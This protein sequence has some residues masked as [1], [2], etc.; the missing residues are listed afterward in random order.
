[1]A[2]RI[3]VHLGRRG[4]GGL[5]IALPCST[6]CQK[7]RAVPVATAKAKGCL[8]SELQGNRPIGR[9]TAVLKAGVFNRLTRT[10][11][12]GID[13]QMRALSGLIWVASLGV[14]H[15]LCS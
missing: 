4:R 2:D 13:A 10:L 6:C 8:I 14:Y 5:F 1:M 3:A 12:D 11:V 9:P 7:A 15:C